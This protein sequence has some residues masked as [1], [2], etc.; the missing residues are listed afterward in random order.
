MGNEPKFSLK[1]TISNFSTTKITEMNRILWKNFFS[2]CRNCSMFINRW[3]R[4]KIFL[5]PSIIIR[6]DESVQIA[7]TLCISWC[8][9]FNEFHVSICGVSAIGMFRW[10]CELQ[11]FQMQSVRSFR[12]K[13]REYS[14]NFGRDTRIILILIITIVRYRWN[15]V[16]YRLCSSVNV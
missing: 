14:H 8:K 2:L 13:I 12:C 15:N 6:A 3:N 10:I 4:R 9:Y 7:L 5:D 1:I 11:S 16:K